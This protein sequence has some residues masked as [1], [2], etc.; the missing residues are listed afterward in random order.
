MASLPLEIAEH[1]LSLL[2][3]AQDFDA[4]L[5]ADVLAV[6][7]RVQ[8]IRRRLAHTKKRF[9]ILNGDLDALR[10]MYDTRG[11]RF[12]YQDVAMAA[13]NGNFKMVRWLW[14]RATLGHPHGAMSAAV[15]A[16]DLGMLKW[17]CERIRPPDS[18]VDSLIECAACIVPHLPIIKWLCEHYN[19]R[20]TPGAL[21]TLAVSDDVQAMDYLYE[22]N[23]DNARYLTRIEDDGN[24][25]D[26]DDA[27]G[28]IFVPKG[29]AGKIVYRNAQHTH[30]GLID[31]AI[32]H[33]QYSMVK[34]LWQK[35]IGLYTYR[36][37]RYALDSEDPRLVEFVWCHRE[38][39]EAKLRPWPM[40]EAAASIR[41]P[42]SHGKLVSTAI[43][44]NN[45][46]SLLMLANLFGVHP[47]QKALA[48]AIMW[49]HER[50]VD[51]LLDRCGIVPANDSLVLACRHG[52][53]QIVQRL[54]QAGAVCTDAALGEAVA[55][56]HID[57]V[58]LLCVK[59]TCRCPR[60]FLH[61]AASRGHLRT[62]RAVDYADIAAAMPKIVQN[63]VECGRLPVVRF[64]IEEIGVA[65]HGPNKLLSKAI[66]SGSTDTLSF[67]CERI[68]MRPNGHHMCDA[69]LSPVCGVDD[70]IASRAA[71]V[72]S[73]AQLLVAFDAAVR[74]AKPEMARLFQSHLIAKRV[75][76]EED[77]GGGEGTP[78][79]DSQD[80][81]GDE[82]LLPLEIIALPKSTGQMGCIALEHLNEVAGDRIDW[83][84]SPLPGLA[85]AAGRIEIL[86]WLAERHLM[87]PADALRVDMSKAIIYDN[88]RVVEWLWRYGCRPDRT[89][90]RSE[91]HNATADMVRAL[92]HQESDHHR[93]Q[94][95]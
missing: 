82:P 48:K 44:G 91:C 21:F 7:A 40:V 13:R 24:D 10:Y 77:G 25:A 32:L 64:L 79:G 95:E 33:G 88:T 38:T 36:V 22:R 11:C 35:R 69:V 85:I 3:L 50:M 76:R 66:A 51:Y 45:I 29:P 41:G 67:L 9:L 59:T 4:C 16:H 84:G 53:A 68:G 26:G 15:E 58:N 28:D 83:R 78:A 19:R 75:R 57:V 27:V 43:F 12:R 94:Q 47:E 65:I 80:E 42:V 70:Y 72:A 90:A 30:R 61:Q 52:N 23:P 74:M 1:I 18:K 62:I 86:K 73:R 46:A 93:R 63:A 39:I 60:A 8:R 87:P 81:R 54:L 89:I 71:L 37:L 49:R 2:P 17:L 14:K 34:H 56:N 20:G 92:E 55:N 31:T 6:D 5:D